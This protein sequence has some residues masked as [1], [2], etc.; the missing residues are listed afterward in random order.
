MNPAPVRYS[1]SIPL[2][3]SGNPYDL[4]KRV[5]DTLI[6]FVL[7]LLLAPLMVFLAVAVMIDSPGGA[8][9]RQERVG[10]DG[11]PFRLLKFRSMHR[12]TPDISTAEMRQQGKNPITKIGHF[13][14]RTSLD[15][16]PQ[17]LNVLC[18]QMSLVGPRPA[19][20]SQEALNQMRRDAGVDA[21]RPGIT[22]W[23]QIN[24]RDE[25]TDEQKV[26]HDTY[27]RHHYSLGLDV[28][29]LIRTVASV[30]SGRGSR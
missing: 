26:A 13:L 16:L 7:L 27:Y 25:L 5:F 29:I 20:R 3:V 8:F 24:G 14:R 1:P 9:F 6:S 12:G 15:E 22:G 19:L 23:A 2:S 17:L 21:L 28:A 30:I 4:T 18:G 11:L 10:T